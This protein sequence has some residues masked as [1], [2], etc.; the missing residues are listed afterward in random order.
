MML[1]GLDY[2][3]VDEVGSIVIVFLVGEFEY[4]IGDFVVGVD[5]FIDGCV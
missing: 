5:F 1:F 2:G 4:L 3:F